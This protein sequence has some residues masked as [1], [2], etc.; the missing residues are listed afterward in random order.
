MSLFLGHRD[1]FAETTRGWGFFWHDCYDFSTFA[2]RNQTQADV[3]PCRGLVSDPPLEG[4]SSLVRLFLHAVCCRGFLAV[5][6]SVPVASPFR[7]ADPPIEPLKRRLCQVDLGHG[8]VDGWLEPGP[9]PVVGT[10]ALLT[11]GRLYRRASP[12]ISAVARKCCERYL[13]VWWW[14]K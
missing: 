13:A 5:D 14:L 11:G 7:Q 4:M 2:H 12:S 6:G 10:L 9:L 8:V 3:S 1:I